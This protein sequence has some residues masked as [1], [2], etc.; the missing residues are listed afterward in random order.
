MAFTGSNAQ[1]RRDVNDRS[2]TR[3]DCPWPQGAPSATHRVNA[4][5]VGSGNRLPG[6]I[7]SDS[8]VCRRAWI[9]RLCSASSGDDRRAPIPALEQ[10]LPRVD[11]EPAARLLAAVAGK[12]GL[13]EDR[14]DLGLETLLGPAARLT[15]PAGASL[16]RR[17]G[18]QPADDH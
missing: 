4:A 2:V 1:C 14:P 11:P 15:P 12:T 16:V 7:V 3:S 8:S 6:G 17:Q 9:S 13:H 18:K 10:G 5:T